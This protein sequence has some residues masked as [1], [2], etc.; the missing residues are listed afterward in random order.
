MSGYWDAVVKK[1]RLALSWEA[2][3]E[4]KLN[5]EDSARKKDTT[6]MINNLEVVGWQKSAPNFMLYDFMEKNVSE[7][8]PKIYED[9]LKIFLSSRYEYVLD[10]FRDWEV[11]VVFWLDWENREMEYKRLELK[12]IPELRGGRRK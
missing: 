9:L 1:L 5:S 2:Q 6:G 10:I 11:K 8:M 3:W 7:A 4:D 12:S